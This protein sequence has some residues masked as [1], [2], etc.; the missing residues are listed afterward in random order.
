M[1][2]CLGLARWEQMVVV[3]FALHWKLRCGPIPVGSREGDVPFRLCPSCLVK[4]KISGIETFDIGI[5]RST[6]KKCIHV[7][8]WLLSLVFSFA[9]PVMDHCASSFLPL[10]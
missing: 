8:W 3:P 6:T 9:S 7:V 10:I 1:E 4:I 2:A 5:I